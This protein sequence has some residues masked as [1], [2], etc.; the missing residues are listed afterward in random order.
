MSELTRN[1][2]RQRMRNSYLSGGMEN[3]PDH[4]L[5]ELYLSLVIPQKDVKPLAYDLMNTF[6]SLENVINA[7]A[8]ELMK[9]NGIGQS[10]AVALNLVG[11][12]NKRI[13]Y[14]RIHNL[15]KI[16]STEQAYEYCYNLIG[17][18]KV[19]KV[20]II[21]LTNDG[22]VINHHILN[23]GNVGSVSVDMRKFVGFALN[24]NAAGVLITHNHPNGD[25]KPSAADINFTIEMNSM[26]RKIKVNLVDHI[27][28]G[29][30]SY[31]SVKS[32]PNFMMTI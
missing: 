1:G 13:V 11:D 5:L 7:R 22:T 27:I 17:L 15:K 24:D 6:G 19:E 2:H 18:E 26:L 31:L 10:A 12:I 3:A 16:N 20:A 14:N 9:I 30:D 29:K 32:H 25:S 4:N 8:D 23:E 28:I 21:T